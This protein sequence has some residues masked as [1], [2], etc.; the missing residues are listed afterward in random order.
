MRAWLNLRYALAERWQAFA[1]GLE[2]LGYRVEQGVTMT[3]G[4]RDLLCTWNR[5]GFGE[6][7]A[8][9]FEAA[10]LPVLVAENAAW[11]NE[12]QGGGWVSLARGLH[13]TAGRFPVGDASRWDAL[14]VELAP[15]RSG[16]EVVI[17]PQRGIGSAPVAMP[18]WWPERA[19][20][21]T[22]GRIRR[23]PGREPAVAL[24]RDLERARLVVT[25]GSG[26]AVKAL[27]WGVPVESE[28]PGWIGQQDN[29]NEGR[30]AMLRRMA[31]AQWRH[32][33][34]ASGEAFRWLLTAP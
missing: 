10:E 4:P 31:W 24:E 15:W 32:E 16:D 19:R 17:L 8:R 33:E 7:A 5:I 27:L 34:L 3:P 6:Q 14:G 11:G 18:A 21:A 30:L 13:N 20:Q 29:T 26:A 28:Y 2:R 9:I 25:W 12:F 22:G 1:S 23:H